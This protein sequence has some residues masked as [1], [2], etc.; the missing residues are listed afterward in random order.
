MPPGRTDRSFVQG[1]GRAGPGTRSLN[2]VTTMKRTHARHAR[3]HTHVPVCI[4]ALLF[5]STRI[6]QCIDIHKYTDF[7]Q[8]PACAR[9]EH[10][11]MHARTHWLRLNWLIFLNHGSCNNNKKNMGRKWDRERAWGSFKREMYEK[12]IRPGNNLSAARLIIHH[13]ICN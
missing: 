2:T 8:T 10:T 6:L 1:A 3:M 11:S 5:A 4:R 13:L 12:Q 7:K 9:R